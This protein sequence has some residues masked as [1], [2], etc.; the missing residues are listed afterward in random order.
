MVCLYA[1][2]LLDNTFGCR[3]V[4]QSIVTFGEVVVEVCPI[5]RCVLSAVDFCSCEQ[6]KSGQQKGKPYR[7]RTNMVYFCPKL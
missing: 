6:D 7:G 4:S 1:Q 3:D 5:C 2:Y